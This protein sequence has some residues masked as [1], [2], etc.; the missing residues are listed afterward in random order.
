MQAKKQNKYSIKQ[1]LDLSNVYAKLKLGSGS[2][3]KRLVKQSKWQIIDRQ[4]IILCVKVSV[5]DSELSIF[6]LFSLPFLV[7]KSKFHYLNFTSMFCG[8]I[9]GLP[10]AR[11]NT[12]NIYLSPFDKCF[13]HFSRFVAHD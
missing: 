2:T 5:L 3:L 8:P 4:A 12:I 13:S 7:D 9:L 11:F 10:L 6:L 1:T